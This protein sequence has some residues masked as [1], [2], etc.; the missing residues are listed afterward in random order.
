[1]LDIFDLRKYSGSEEGLLRLLPVVKTSRVVLLMGY[2]LTEKCCE[3]LAS[4]LS[5]SQLRTLNLND[6]DL[7]DSGVKLLSGGLR[8]PHCKLEVLILLLYGIT[9]EGCASLTLVPSSN[10][11]HL[12]ELNLDYSHIGDSGVKI[13][14]AALEH[15]DCNVKLRCL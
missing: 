14:S 13:L 12:R 11:S 7:Q 9:E 15:P 3:A 8:S 4:S 6:N 2:N 1:M 5:S 10:P